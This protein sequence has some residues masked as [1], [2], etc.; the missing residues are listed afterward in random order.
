[1]RKKP[2]KSK[3]YRE[4][5]VTEKKQKD[6]TFVIKKICARFSDRRL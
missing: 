6:D 2:M 4:I 5:F 3:D 1:M